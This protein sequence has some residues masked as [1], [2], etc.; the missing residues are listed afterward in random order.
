M[1]AMPALA[2]KLKVFA[3]AEGE[4]IQ[5]SAYFA[6]GAKATGASIL[7]QDADGHPLAS[8]SPD[9]DGRFSYRALASIEHVVIARSD[10]GHRAEWRIAAADLA[11]AFPVVDRPAE[12][13]PPTSGTPD[14][15]VRA[16]SE[17]ADQRG[18]ED[19]PTRS[20]QSG[21]RALDPALVLFIEEA[22]ARQ[23]R[24]LR[25]QLVAIDDRIRFQDV[26][27]GIGYILGLTGLALWWRCRRTGRRTDR[28]R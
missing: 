21:D 22:V 9:G 23:V 12:A 8:L 15:S 2:H 16:T 28:P 24:P 18:S 1:T 11:G 27:G 25:E 7:I 4:R 3:F 14:S 6:G 5:G 13:S 10:D 26:L 20:L 19:K 17:S